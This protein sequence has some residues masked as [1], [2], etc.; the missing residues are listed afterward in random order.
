MSHSST[1]AEYRSLAM[2]TS[3]L[4]WVEFLLRELHIFRRQTLILW[5]DN[6]GA[7][8]I[9]INQVFNARTKHIKIDYHFVR[10]IVDNKTLLIHHLNTND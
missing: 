7:T 8:Y 1:E 2:A 10:E 3:E 4:V 5:C 9:A 6:I